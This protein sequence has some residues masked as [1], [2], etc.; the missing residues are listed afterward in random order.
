LQRL[1]HRHYAEKLSDRT[2]R[3]AIEK[4]K[5]ALVRKGYSFSEVNAAIQQYQEALS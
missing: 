3:N 4:T 5:A 2:D 1:I